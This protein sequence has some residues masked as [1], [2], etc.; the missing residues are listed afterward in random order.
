MN[1]EKVDAVVEHYCKTGCGAVV[2][3]YLGTAPRPPKVTETI[4]C[5]GCGADNSVAPG[6]RER[7]QNARACWHKWHRIFGSFWWLH[8]P[9]WRG[10]WLERERDYSTR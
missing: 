9:P 5:S 8:I 3:S 7:W 6:L 2:W 10:F 4:L 1:T